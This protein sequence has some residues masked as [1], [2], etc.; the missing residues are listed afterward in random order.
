[1]NSFVFHRLFIVRGGRRQNPPSLNDLDLLKS[2]REDILVSAVL[3]CRGRVDRSSGDKLLLSFLTTDDAENYLKKMLELVQKL[4]QGSSGFQ[5]E[6]STILICE[7]YEVLNKELL[8]LI[9][10]LSSRCSSSGVLLAGKADLSWF[11]PLKLVSDHTRW[12][13]IELELMQESLQ[14]REAL[15][16]KKG[17]LSIRKILLRLAFFIL[18]SGLLIELLLYVVPLAMSWVRNSEVDELVQRMQDL[19][20]EGLYLRLKGLKIARY[21]SNLESVLDRYGVLAWKQYS[22]AGRGGD[23]TMS[24]ELMDLISLYPESRS[25][26]FYSDLLKLDRLNDNLSESA[27]KIWE[28][29][30]DNQAIRLLALTDR[31]LHLSETNDPFVLLFPYPEVMARENDLHTLSLL[32][33]TFANAM[34]RTLGFSISGREVFLNQILS[35]VPDEIGNAV[36]FESLQDKQTQRFRSALT[37][38]VQGQDMNGIKLREILAVRLQGL[39]LEAAEVQ[40]LLGI[41]KDFS[42]IDFVMDWLTEEGARL[43]R[44]NENPELQIV[45]EQAFL[46]FKSLG[47][48]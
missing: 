32:Q 3:D 29:S 18:V 15:A 19:P 47:A 37:L 5:I 25:L 9:R 46:H 2:L 35:K 40:I 24:S 22:W 42:G 11:K 48:R 12:P 26:K 31:L 17:S 28:D 45:F 20:S 27:K 23:T 41:K 34:E 14:E 38:W 36:L 4:N 33:E 30:G 1:M 16:E 21:N 13:L 39:Y 6:H 10:E 7:R 43:K 44:R 8:E